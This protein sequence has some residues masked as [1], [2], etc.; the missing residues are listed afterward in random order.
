[1][2]RNTGS[3]PRGATA[4]CFYSLQSETCSGTT[5]RRHTP[6]P[7]I[8]VSIRCRARRAAELVAFGRLIEAQYKF[9]FAAERDVQRNRNTSSPRPSRSSFLFAAERDVQR[10]RFKAR[11]DP[12]GDEVSIRCRARRAAEPLFGSGAAE[13]T[14]RFYS[15]QS[16]T[17]SGTSR[18]QAARVSSPVSIR[19]RARRAAE[20]GHAAERAA[21]SCFYSLQSETCSGTPRPEPVRVRAR[22]LFA[23][24]R[25]VQRN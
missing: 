12:A 16:E 9:L 6:P 21:P 1:M 5:L 22:F 10:N 13:A 19:C 20:L 25:D 3:V 24:E 8:D 18:Q 23:A 4:W 14:V 15:L 7:L 17:C 11:S 2:Q